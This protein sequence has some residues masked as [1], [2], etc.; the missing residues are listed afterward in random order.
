ME[1]LKLW[2]DSSELALK[3]VVEKQNAESIQSVVAPTQLTLKLSFYDLA[4][5]LDVP[6]MA[7]IHRLHEAGAW[8]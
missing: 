3:A 2:V 7:L 6:P 4:P 5:V 8:R 1:A